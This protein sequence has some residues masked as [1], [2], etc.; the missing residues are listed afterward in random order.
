MTEPSPFLAL[1]DVHRVT[2]RVGGRACDVFIFD[3]HR[4]AF[5][6][7]SLAA[8]AHGG[9]L[10][11]LTL[12]RHMDLG[13]SAQ[14]PPAFDAPVEALDA[15]ARHRLAPSNDDHIVS[16][17][18]AGAI[19]DAAVIARSH[20]PADLNVF[21]PYVDRAGR[22]HPV[23]FSRDVDSIGDEILHRVAR[24]DAIALDVD[25]DCFTT[26]SDGH[27]DEVIPWDQEQIDSFL[28]PPG[29][30]IF[31]TEAL[32]RTRVITIAREPYHCG[33]FDRSALLWRAF[34]EVFFRR[35]L[36]VPAP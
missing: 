16:A 36:G 14:L 26:L 25:L 29:S 13:I 1:A 2:T 34:A 9:P 10:T 24:A 31:W 8:K 20:A 18:E 22:R 19:S 33:G 32:S 17:M 7:W 35:L 3:H 27:P 5:T 4:T 30:E 21:K 6:L 11:L 28:R 23:A 15:F 12:D